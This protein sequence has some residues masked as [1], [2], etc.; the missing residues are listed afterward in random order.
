M[1]LAGRRLRVVERHHRTRL[2][3]LAGEVAGTL[4]RVAVHTVNTGRAVLGD[5]EGKMS[6]NGQLYAIFY[7]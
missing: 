6:E 7:R 4:T 2:A 3:E 1:L 5:R